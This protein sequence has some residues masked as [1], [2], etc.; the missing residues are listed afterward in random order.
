MI[1]NFLHFPLRRSHGIAQLIPFLT[2]HVQ[3]LPCLHQM[4]SLLIRLHS[5]LVPHLYLSFVHGMCWLLPTC[6]LCQPHAHAA[7]PLKPSLSLSHLHS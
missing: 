7:N 4:N 5:R 6:L 1:L 2:L 3:Q